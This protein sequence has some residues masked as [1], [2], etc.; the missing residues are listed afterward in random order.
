MHSI[1]IS[2]Q[3][4]LLPS[5]HTHRGVRT[6]RI[7]L[8]FGTQKW[9]WSYFSGMLSAHPT[10]WEVW[11]TDWYTLSLIFILSLVLGMYSICSLCPWLYFIFRELLMKLCKVRDQSIEKGRCST[12][13]PETPEHILTS[14]FEC[15]IEAQ[16]PGQE[17]Q[18]LPQKSA[19]YKNQH[20]IATA[21]QSTHV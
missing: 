1:S 21:S 8:M 17:F 5:C 18:L 19:M 7:F 20:D 14:Y 12:W 10:S 4:I 2:Q 3:T 6:T 11:H 16:P 9:L 15:L 13:A